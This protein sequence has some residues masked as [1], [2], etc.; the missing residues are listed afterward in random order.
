[1]FSLGLG[2]TINDFKNILKKPK[3]FWIGFVN[4]MIILPIAGLFV[5]YVFS[6]KD[7]IAIGMMILACCP[8]GVTSNI[9]TKI[10]KGDTALSISYTAV[11]SITT[12]ITLPLFL[13]FS[14]KLLG[15]ESQDINILS[16]GLKMFFLTAGPV[17]IGLYV[18][19]R[20]NKFSKLFS[21]TANKVSAIL[22]V[23]IVLFALTKNW[24]TFVENLSSLG[25]AIILLIAIMLFVGFNSSKLFGLNKK[26]G[27]T[28][29]IESGIQ[30]ATVG[31]TVGNL[32]FEPPLSVTLGVIT[33][34]TF[35]VASLP[36]A[37]YGIL[38]YLVCLPFVYWLIKKQ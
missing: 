12:V 37:L 19:S 15:S 38:M 5:I 25:P 4:Q 10:A 36:S 17:S 26:Q 1:M 13:G 29:A 6:L 9:L 18:N 31:V 14:M 3:A 33:R 32:L 20:Y 22:F 28:V 16:T 8:G 34:D 11:A 27:I 7:E 23:I 35:S 30:N 21:S 2:L 24:S